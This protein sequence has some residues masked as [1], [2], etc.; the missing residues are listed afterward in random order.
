MQQE[1][2]LKGDTASERALSC[3]L[4][5]TAIKLSNEPSAK[6]FFNQHPKHQSFTA[7]VF[8]AVE[9]F[10]AQRL[11]PK[12]VRIHE[13]ELA[14][15]ATSYIEMRH[16]ADGQP[17]KSVFFMSGAEASREAQSSLA[18]YLYALGCDVYCLPQA[19]NQ[20]SWK[21]GRGGIFGQYFR[22]REYN[23]KHGAYA[24]EAALALGAIREQG[25]GEI[26]LVGV[27]NG[28]P[29]MMIAASV[30]AKEGIDVNLH[31]FSPGGFVERNIKKT[32]EAIRIITSFLKL[33]WN[34]RGDDVA[35]LLLYKANGLSAHDNRILYALF[36]ARVGFTLTSSVFLDV[37][38]R[39]IPW[40]IKSF[41]ITVGNEDSVFAPSKTRELAGR[42][43]K[44][45]INFQAIPG[46][47][48]HWTGPKAWIG[49][50]RLME[51]LE[52]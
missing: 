32:R 27:S 7:N 17:R 12:V 8:P 15:S 22:I 44:E 35:D 21:H 40:R 6:R 29:A 28:S 51:Q 25:L 9:K 30:L 13:G 1:P 19:I 11:F 3:W 33:G 5:N 39:G 43:S 50:I 23:K 18:V 49:A 38:E 2:P 24:A 52:N 10:N 42:V 16:K 14:G 34:L 36:L 47:E 37:F 31:L 45:R 20:E 41:G 26:T 46:E 4:I 48:H